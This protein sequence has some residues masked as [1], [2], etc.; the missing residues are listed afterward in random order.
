MVNL[1]DVALVQKFLDRISELEVKLEN[2][3]K[4]AEHNTAKLIFKE[5]YDLVQ[6]AE[7]TITVDAND[8]KVIA[9]RYG[10]NL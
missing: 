4:N 1:D 9:R 10:V 5:L 3:V 7:C 6:G 2:E 8:I